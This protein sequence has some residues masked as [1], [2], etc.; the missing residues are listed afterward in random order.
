MSDAPRRGGPPRPRLPLL[1]RL[2]DDAP[3]RPE[4]PPLSAADALDALRRS[5]GRDLQWLLNTRRHW[6]S[7]PAALRGLEV[8]PLGYG[9]PDFAAGAFQ[10]PG[11]REALRREVEETIRRFE[12][13]FLSLRVT[14]AEAED[15]LSGTLRLRIDALLRAEP[16]PEPIGFVTLLDPATDE[17]TVHETHGV[18]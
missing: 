13:R 15:T 18:G 6:R 16:A 17:V 9:L 7:L 12:T 5:V 11:R 4:D 8:S 14:L 3:D 1:D 10:D 2:I